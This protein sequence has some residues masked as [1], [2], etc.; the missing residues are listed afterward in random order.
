MNVLGTIAI[1]ALVG[2]SMVACDLLGDEDLCADGHTPGNYEQTTAPTVS[3][4][5]ITDG[6][7][8]QYCTECDA[9]IDTR[10]LS[11]LSLFE[12]TWESSGSVA[13]PN[14]RWTVVITGSTFT[15]RVNPFNAQNWVQL[16]NA[17]FTK[18]PNLNT[19]QANFNAS[20]FPYGYD[21]TLGSGTK[22]QGS[23]TGDGAITGN[24]TIKIYMK[25]DLSG[26][27]LVLGTQ[28]Q[29]RTFTKVTTP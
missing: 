1:V 17:T 20:V 14:Q 7:E 24:T 25:P 6:E 19:D 15:I 16:A 8:T 13:A 10:V 28:M 9:V 4:T 26:F 27:A 18:A 22:T 21:I 2:F 5:G 11:A 29:T 12:G 23:Y 3:S